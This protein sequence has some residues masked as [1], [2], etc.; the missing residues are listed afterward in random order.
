MHKSHTV[1]ATSTHAVIAALLLFANFGLYAIAA[2]VRFLEVPAGMWWFISAVIS[3]LAACSYTR[4]FFSKA[5]WLSLIS[6]ALIAIGPVLYLHELM[7]FGLHIGDLPSNDVPIRYSQVVFL[8]SYAIFGIILWKDKQVPN[9]IPASLW[10]MSAVWLANV[11]F[12]GDI[13]LRIA[14]SL[15]LDLLSFLAFTL[16]IVWLLLFWRTGKDNQATT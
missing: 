8:L 3:L 15:L 2:I 4:I 14:L 13:Q 5:P 16:F 10:A 7:T 11:G 6:L 1:R 9:Y 12:R